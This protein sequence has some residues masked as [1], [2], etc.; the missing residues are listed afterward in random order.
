MSRDSWNEFVKLLDM[1][2]NEALERK[3][4]LRMSQVVDHPS[5]IALSRTSGIKFSWSP[6][7]FHG[8]LFN[9]HPTYSILRLAYVNFA[10]SILCE[11]AGDGSMFV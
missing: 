11:V 3:D 8:D 4:L 1:F 10:D 6:P 9:P 2:G 7:F 5:L